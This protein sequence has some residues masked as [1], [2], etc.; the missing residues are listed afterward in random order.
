[1]PFPDRKSLANAVLC[2]LASHGGEVD[3]EACNIYQHL[4]ETFA[5]TPEEL[6][7]EYNRGPGKT[8]NKW[9]QDLRM[10]REY[11]KRQGLIASGSPRG[12]W[13]LTPEGYTEG[14][15]LLGQRSTEITPEL[16][17]D[18][19]EMTAVVAPERVHFQVDDSLHSRT[20]A[21]Q[22][23]TNQNT[24][25][26][27][28]AASPTS[29]L[30]ANASNGISR[31]EDSVGTKS[32]VLDPQT[33]AAGFQNL[34]FQVAES[35]DGGFVITSP[36]ADHAF[37][38]DLWIVP[39]GG[40]GVFRARR[41]PTLL[42]VESAESVAIVPDGTLVFAVQQLDR[43]FRAHRDSPFDLDE[44]VD[45]FRRAAD[46][47]AGAIDELIQR[48]YAALP[49][50]ELLVLVIEHGSLRNQ[51]GITEPIRPEHVYWWLFGQPENR[52]RYTVDTIE[53]ALDVLANP[54]FGVLRREAG[55]YRQIQSLD[56]AAERLLSLANALAQRAGMGV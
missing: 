42:V 17:A 32:V 29:N 23:P 48:H 46:G 47:H 20:V 36:V 33:L 24:T 35:G 53:R 6:A 19:V 38:A 44:L 51:H 55:G 40:R 22:G 27:E 5:L 30:V 45:A 28:S 41:R 3:V 25:E 16:V 39:R 18:L 37:E 31:E 9:V 14:L 52:G 11:L 49:P 2:Y 50:V 4:A 15:R 7:E 21:E 1:M 12:I 34:G 13:R 56:G 43:L 8:V 54:V 26:G 10:I